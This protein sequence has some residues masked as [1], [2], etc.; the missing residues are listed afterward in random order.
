MLDLKFESQEELYERVLPALKS[1]RKLLLL[2]GFKSVKKSDIWEY[3]RETK[4]SNINGLELCDLVDDI[5]N[6]DNSMI[7]EYCT[8]KRGETNTPKK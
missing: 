8:N 4:W 5:L 2:D 6:A 1:K 7:Y 3:L